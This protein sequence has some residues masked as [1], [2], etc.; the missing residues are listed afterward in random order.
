M[1]DL[2]DTTRLLAAVRDIDDWPQPGV[3]FKDITPLLGDPTTFGEAVEILAAAGR[4]PGG[5]VVV[6]KVIGVEARGFILG[7]PVALTLGV[8]FV[9][10]RKEGKLPHDTHAASYALEYG[11][12]TVEV[13]QDAFAPGDRVLVIDDV[14]ATGGT[15]AATAQLV[16]R[17]GGRVV[18]VAV[19]LE[20]GVLGGRARLAT[21]PALAGV[22]LRVVL[23]V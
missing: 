7:A 16:T 14:L 11:E 21:E 15:L 23:P 2:P 10:I 5:E 8:G 22:P 13:H 19:L 4:G 17:A 9:P 18:A 3:V 1:T 12:A 20:I 6:D